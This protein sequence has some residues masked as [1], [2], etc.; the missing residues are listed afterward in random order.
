M[1]NHLSRGLVVVLWLASVAVAI[2]ELTSI[3]DALLLLYGWIISRGGTD[4]HSLYDSYWSSVFIG[5]LLTIILAIGV[6][7]LAVG[8]G[9]YQAKHGGERQIWRLFGWIFGIE[10]IIFLITYPF[11]S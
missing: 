9:E 2:L 11:I 4:L 1:N 8:V 10:A 7:A 3:R 6:L 5:Q